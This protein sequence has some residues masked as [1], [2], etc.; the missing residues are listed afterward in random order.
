MNNRTEDFA[1][2]EVRDDV[3]RGMT[4]LLRRLLMSVLRQWRLR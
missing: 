1:A 3:W 4:R 2:S